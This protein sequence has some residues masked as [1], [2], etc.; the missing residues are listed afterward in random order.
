VSEAVYF[1]TGLVLY[2]TSIL[3]E[4]HTNNEIS[5]PSASL[6]ELL[7]LYHKLVTVFER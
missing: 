3:R 5:I 7:Q 4:Y 2:D 1:T 6:I